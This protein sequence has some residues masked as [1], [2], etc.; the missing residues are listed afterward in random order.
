MLWSVIIR[1]DATHMHEYPDGMLHGTKALLFLLVEPWLNTS[2]TTVGDDSY[3][4][5]V[6]GAGALDDWGMEFIGVVKTAT[7]RFPMAYLS[8][9]N[10]ATD[11]V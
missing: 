2:R 7:K 1:H 3:F 4:V 11:M 10:A 8:N 5:L 6:G 9:Y